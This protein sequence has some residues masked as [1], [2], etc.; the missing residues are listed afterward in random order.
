MYELAIEHHR[1]GLSQSLHADRTAALERLSSYSETLDSFP[2]SIQLTAPFT[3]Y[4]FIDQAD[5][6]A[7][8]IATIEHHAA[9]PATETA[10][11]AIT[12]VLQDTPSP[13]AA[14]GTIA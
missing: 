14:D 2:H 11:P 10:L 13:P 1:S 3:S 12:V 9:E 8:A 4:E 6:R 5:G 7:I